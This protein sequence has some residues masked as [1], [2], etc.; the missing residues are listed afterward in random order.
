MH[1]E[2]ALDDLMPAEAAAIKGQGRG[3]AFPLLDGETQ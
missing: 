1:I 2:P 3:N